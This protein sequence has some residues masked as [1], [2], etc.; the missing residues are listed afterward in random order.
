M[1]KW[2]TLAALIALM[3]P[4]ATSAGKSLDTAKAPL[5]QLIKAESIAIMDARSG[6]V[7]NSIRASERKE[8][9]SLQKIVTA[10]VI[11]RAGNLNKQVTITPQDA[12]CA[13]TKLPSSVG[14]TYTRMELL[15]A[16]LIPSAN[17]AA[18]ALARDHSGSEEAFAQQMTALARSLGAKNTVF[19]NSTGLPAAG[20]FSTASD[21]ALITRAAYG[22]G[23]LRRIVRTKFLPW[24]DARGR[25]SELRNANR[26]LHRHPNCTGMKI[27]YT[28]VAGHCAAAVWEE[29]GRTIIGIVL[30]G[31][32]QMFWLQ[33]GL[34]L[35]LYANGLL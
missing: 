5:D 8:V 13:P 2:T 18:R 28:G 12:A 34:V 26:L 4:A 3:L 21:M 20:Q 16:A 30:A 35:K 14:G 31:R 19:K 11:I 33:T 22:N 25:M 29:N 23:L 15:Q 24:R 7:L 10:L 1:G 32:D 27:G 6:K 9:A 17:D